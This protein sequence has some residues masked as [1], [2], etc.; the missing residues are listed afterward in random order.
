MLEII[1]PQNFKQIPWKNGQGTTIE[2]AINEEGTVNDFDWRLS[3]ATVKNDGPFSDFSG[4]TRNLVL[5]AGNG[6]SLEHSPTR[7]DRLDELLQFST[8]DGGCDTKATL[9]NGPITDFNLMTRT[10]RFD[11]RLETYRKPS[12]IKLEKAL[13]SFVY[14]LDEDLSIQSNKT[15][16]NFSLKPRELAK[17]T[18]IQQQDWV[19][20]GRNFIIVY[21]SSRKLN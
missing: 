1:P 18:D 7:V 5:I 16:S 20:S 17:F 13:I 4:Y 15:S 8:F 10:N 2:L 12:Q 21:I 19:V 14:S 9:I 11:A 3:I 6:L